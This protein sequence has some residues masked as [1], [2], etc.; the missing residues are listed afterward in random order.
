MKRGIRRFPRV[1]RASRLAR[2]W[3]HARRGAYPDF[4][5]LIAELPELWQSARAAAAG[6]PRVLM[7][8]SIGSYA[9]AVTLESA[10]AAALTFRG[11]EVHA[12]LCDGSMTACAECD[13]SLYPD[14]SR[15]V[16][17]GPARDLCRD[18]LWPAERVYGQL[19]IR[20]HRYGDWLTPD[21]RADARRLA[22]AFPYDEIRN[23]TLDGLAIGEHAYAGAL[24]FFATASL[25][26]E[27]GAEAVLRRYLEASLLTVSATRTLLRAVGFTSAVFTHGIYV[28]WG[29]IGEVARQERVRVSTWNVAYRKR[30]FIFSHDDTYH[31]TL[32]NEPRSHWENNALT[33]AQDSELMKYLKTRRDGLFD[34][35]V[36]HRPTTQDA[37]A[38]ATQLGVDRSKP[39][40]GLLTNVSW[41]AQLHYPANAFPN[42]L[43][44]LVETCRY[45]ATRPDLQLLIRVHPAEISGFP[46]SRQ[47]I[48]G[49]LKRRLPTLAS[50]VIVVPPESGISTYA[51]M[52]LCNSAIIYGTKMGVELTSVGMPVIVAGEAWIRNKGLTEDASSPEEYF[53]ILDRL[54]FP[55]PLGPAQLARARQYAYHFFFN[56]M[57]PLPFVEPKA[58]YPIYRLKLETLKHLFPGESRGLD[59]ICDGILGKGTFVMSDSPR[60]PELVT[61][62]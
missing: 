1:W 48:L 12:L 38:I 46:P 31:H 11:A 10:L 19:G 39:V 4:S 29:I 36:F 23:L 16:A 42:M 56:R 22:V 37:D 2:R 21:D 57:I 25:D 54:P 9:H 15:F 60:T 35:I 40:I 5:T 45:F 18:C 50:N 7:A 30:R 32:M 61:S 3:L 20:V 51:V 17:H 58:G 55:S 59:T 62:R 13:A 53:R 49:E 14:I 47:P 8:S 44:W 27:P 34:W 33:P 26:D 28:P 24:R 41:D 52:S 43:E 6:G